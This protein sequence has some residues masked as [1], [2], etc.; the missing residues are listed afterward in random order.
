MK[1]IKIKLSPEAEEVYHYLNKESS[2]SKIE[3]SI[4][5][6]ISKK[7]DLIKE[8]PHYGSP[9]AKKLIPKEYIEKYNITNLFHVELPNFWRMLYTLTN[10]GSE[11]EIIAFVLD[12]LGHNKYNKK[13]GYKK[14]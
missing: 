6:A 8:N 2:N 5:N 4:F 1:I 13:F 10:D 7:K 3:K 11:V 12:I 9:I 14:H